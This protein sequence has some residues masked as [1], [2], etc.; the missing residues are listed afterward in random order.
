MQSPLFELLPSKSGNQV[1]RQSNTAALAT[2]MAREARSTPCS[3]A[4]RLPAPTHADPD[5][6]HWGHAGTL[7]QMAEQLK[8][9]AEFL[10]V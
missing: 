1:R 7:G 2:F 5:E 4:F 3:R 6:V 8:E 10:R 9:I